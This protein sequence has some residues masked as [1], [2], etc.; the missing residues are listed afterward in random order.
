M[1]LEIPFTYN[2]EKTNNFFKTISPTIK[3]LGYA[4]W[5]GVI[6]YLFYN[7]LNSENNTYFIFSMVLLGMLLQDLY[8][9]WRKNKK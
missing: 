5:V 8:S 2:S 7:S 1:A 3:Y 4:F 6:I 9:K